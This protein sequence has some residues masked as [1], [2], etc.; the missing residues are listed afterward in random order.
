MP[1]ASPVARIVLFGTDWVTSTGIATPAATRAKKAAFCT[2]PLMVNAIYIYHPEV[3][4]VVVIL[5]SVSGRMCSGSLPALNN[6]ADDVLA[7][8]FEA[9]DKSLSSPRKA[10]GSPARRIDSQ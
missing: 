9:L 3:P 2:I 4:S 1:E 8:P 6:N 5:F 10:Q 7:L